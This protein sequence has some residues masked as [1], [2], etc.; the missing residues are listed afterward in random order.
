MQ[1]KYL[2]NQVCEQALRNQSMRR[3]GNQ[4]KR[5]IHLL[6]IDFS[7]YSSFSRWTA[8][9]SCPELSPAC[10]AAHHLNYHP[11]IHFKD[12]RV[13]VVL[14]LP[15]ASGCSEFSCCSSVTGSL[16]FIVKCLAR[17]SVLSWNVHLMCQVTAFIK[18]G[19][20]AW[21]YCLFPVWTLSCVKTRTPDQLCLVTV[22]KASQRKVRAT[23]PWGMLRV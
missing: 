3:K 17:L 13:V 12:R 20:H 4:M 5:K 2:N 23:W 14:E 9:T 11:Q 16:A 8:L 21:C 18:L 15:R 22:G 6:W 19:W 7:K 1:R 10:F